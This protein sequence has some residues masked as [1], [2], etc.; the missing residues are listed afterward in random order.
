MLPR[1]SRQPGRQQ[2]LV[3][4]LLR[5]EYLARDAVGSLG[6]VHLDDE[7]PQQLAEL[8]VVHAIGHPA[9]LAAHA[10][11]A[12]VED[13]HRDLERILRDRDHVGI[14]P[15]R[16]HDGVLLHRPLEGTDVVAQPGRVL[17]LLGVGGLPHLALEPLHVLTG[18]PADE[19]A[20]VVDDLAMLLGSHPPDT[21]RRAL[22]DVA[23]QARPAD[24]GAALEHPGRAGAHREDTQEQVDGLADRPSVGVRPE[25]AD[26]LLLGAAADHDPRILL[27]Q[28]HR[29]PRIRL[30]VAVLHVESRVELLD[31][32]VLE[33][34]RL[35]LGLHHR[36]LD[37]GGGRHHG[38]GA[39]VEVGDV[40]EVRRDPRTQRLR[41]AD[42]DDSPLGIAEAID[43]RRVGNRSRRRAVRRGVGHPPTLRGR[44]ST[45]RRRHAVPKKGGSGIPW[46][47]NLQV[48][49]QSRVIL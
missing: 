39:L 45:V 20:E 13:L 26:A 19:R 11:T 31:P 18:L 7:P 22:A 9:A 35:D 23:E 8:C 24:L 38:R 47:E 3:V 43:A 32:G 34:E 37:G 15:V 21:R 14:G 48:C 6:V 5:N 30:V 40:L 36:P 25:V 49:P 44:A 10:S 27:V 42:V 41:L 4:G 2:R 1:L 16:Q 17:V 29:E 33:L 12:H 46:P 28:R